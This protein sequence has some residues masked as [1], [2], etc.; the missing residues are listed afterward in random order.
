M[1]LIE[2]MMRRI[3]RRPPIASEIAE[4]RHLAELRRYEVETDEIVAGIRDK[5][6]RRKNDR[7]D[8][9][10]LFALIV[11]AAISMLV[12]PRDQW[13]PYLSPAL[14]AGAFFRWV[15]VTRRRGA[16]PDRS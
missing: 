11:V 5:D 14:F 4:R 15:W 16:P 1:C 8:Q 13:S 6:E 12:M 3:S 10:I 7:L 9:W 2:K